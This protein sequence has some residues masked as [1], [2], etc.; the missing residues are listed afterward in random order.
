[1]KKITVLVIGNSINISGGKKR[2]KDVFYGDL[3][4]IIRSSR[5]KS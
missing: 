3:S 5:G 4:P 1:M 2:L